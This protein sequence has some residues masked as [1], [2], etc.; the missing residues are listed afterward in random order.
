MNIITSIREEAKESDYEVGEED[1]IRK[2][3]E[4]AIRDINS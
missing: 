2:S 4:K 3:L 1:S